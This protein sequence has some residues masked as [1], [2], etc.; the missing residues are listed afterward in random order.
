VDDRRQPGADEGAGPEAEVEQA[1]GPAEAGA[2]E[3]PRL[4]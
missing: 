4:G 1:G 3:R 2:G